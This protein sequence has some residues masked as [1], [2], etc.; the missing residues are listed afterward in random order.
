MKITNMAQL[1]RLMKQRIKNATN[2]ASQKM[3]ADLYEE[4]GDFYTGG[5]P[6][7]Y[8]RTGALGDTPQIGGIT[9]KG[10]TIEL[11]MKLDD[12]HQYTTGKSPTMEDILNLTNYGI[13]NSKNSGY[14]R[15]TVGKQGYWE[16]A[17]EKMKEDYIETMGNVFK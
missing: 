4:T 16:R 9:E 5:E 14:L 2:A 15:K 3:L 17:K 12:S 8:E 11:E 13:T 10:N 1:E 6:K 7:V